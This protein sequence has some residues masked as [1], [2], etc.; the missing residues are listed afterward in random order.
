MQS[1]GR[2]L[3]GFLLTVVL[4]VCGTAVPHAE[5]NCQISES[6]ALRLPKATLFVGIVDAVSAATTAGA[7]VFV[8]VRV[9]EVFENRLGLTSAIRGHQISGILASGICAKNLRVGKQYLW[10]VTVR[11]VRNKLEMVLRTVG[12]KLPQTETYGRGNEIKGLD[13]VLAERAD[14]PCAGLHCHAGAVCEIWNDPS[15]ERVGVCTCMSIS[16]LEASGRCTRRLGRV[17]A[18]NGRLYDSQCHLLQA[19]CLQQTMV[20]IVSWTAVNEADCLQQATRNSKPGQPES[21]VSKMEEVTINKDKPA[22]SVNPYDQPQHDAAFMKEVLETPEAATCELSCNPDEIQ[23]VCGSDGRTYLN[24]CLLEHY[25]CL[26]FQR[27]GKHPVRVK[28]WGYCPAIELEGQ[29]ELCSFANVCLYG[30]RCTRKG[31]DDDADYVGKYRQAK[32]ICSC[33]HLSCE[34]T[35]NDK[36]V[37]G[38]D[39]ST[40]RSECF[41]RRAAC[42]SQSPKKV[43]FFEA[44]P[45]NPCL[46]QTCSW[47]GEQCRVD[48]RGGKQCVCRETCPRV[49]VP[50]CGSDG[51]TYDSVCVLERAACLQKKHV[52]VVHAGQCPQT[53]DECVRYGRPCKGYEVCI[54]RPVV[55][56]GLPSA[57]AMIMSRGSNQI[58]MTPQ[59]T[60]P[61]CPEDGLGNN[62]CGTDNRT[63]RSECHLRAAACRTK[64]LNLR[65]QSRGPC[66]A[67]KGIK[68]KF[69]SIC[70]TNKLGEPFCTCPTDCVYTGKWVCGSDGRAYENECFLRV[71]SCALQKEIYVLH[72]GKCEECSKNCP[73]GLMCLDG[74]CVCRETCPKS[75]LDQEVCGTDGRIYPSVCELRRQ[76]CLQKTTIK[77]D[78]S[79]VVCR[80]SPLMRNRTAEFQSDDAL[81]DRCH[82]NKIGSRDPYC[83]EDGTCRCHWGV[84][85]QKCDHCVEGYWGISNGKPCISCSCNRFGSQEI[86]S[87]DSHSGQCKCKEGITGQQCSI[88]PNGDPVTSKGCPGMDRVKIPSGRRQ[89]D[90]KEIGLFFGASTSALIPFED[91][92]EA[93]ISLH[94]NMTPLSANGEIYLLSFLPREGPGRRFLKLRLTDAHLELAYFTGPK[95]AKMN[96]LVTREKVALGEPMAVH[97]VLKADESLR[98]TTEEAG[99]REFGQDYLGKMISDNEYKQLL[100]SQYDG[101]V[102]GCPSTRSDQ[103]PSCGFSGCLTGIGAELTTPDGLERYVD[104]LSSGRGRHLRWIRAPEGA[105]LCETGVLRRTAWSDHYGVDRSPVEEQASLPEN[106]TSDVCGNENPCLHDGVCQSRA[107]VFVGCICPPGWQSKLCEKE[108]TIIP[109]FNGQ[110]YIR[111]DGPT[112]QQALKKR[113]MTLQ[114]IFTRSSNDGI[115]LAIPPSQPEAEFLS[116]RAEADDCVK[117]HLRVGR[118][119]RFYKLPIYPWLLTKFQPR[120]RIMVSKIC[121]VVHSRWHN[122]TIDKK[123]RQYTVYL[124]GKKMD[125]QTL[126]NEPIPREVRGLRKALTSFDLSHSPLYLGGIPQHETN[127]KVEESIVTN[128]FFVGAIQKVEINGAELVLAGPHPSNSATEHWEN[129]S[130]W[131]GPPCGEDFASCD[132]EPLR[133]ICRPHGEDYTCSCSTPLVHAVFVQRLTNSLAGVDLSIQEQK[134]I[135]TEAEELACA[136][137]M[138]QDTSRVIQGQIGEVQHDVP[139]DSIIRSFSQK[140]PPR[141]IENN[142]PAGQDLDA[143]KFRTTVNFNGSTILKYR[144][145][146]K[147]RK[148]NMLSNNLRLFIRTRSEN[149]LLLLIHNND[150]QSPHGQELLIL[151]VRNGQPEAYLSLHKKGSQYQTNGYQQ[152]TVQAETYVSDGMWHDIQVLRNKGR[153]TVI[154]DSY[155]ESGELPETDGVLHNDGYL[156]LGGFNAAVPS[157][158]SKYSNNFTGCVSAFFIDEQS[159][160]MLIDAE[161]IYGRVSPCQ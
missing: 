141:Q 48:T 106:P 88:C 46:G 122:L 127:L 81:I 95:F 108:V 26:S 63:Y 79:G 18:S 132:S 16:E 52:W 102:V 89:D 5:L 47:T 9:L 86:Q 36:P 90:G 96:Y 49:V 13:S 14:D 115:I 131:Q 8:D 111:L 142:S 117:I 136:E 83:D 33:E 45:E 41:L 4:V 37:C 126:P 159:V 17:C 104:L 116:I 128:N 107:G 22:R 146:L 134:R 148:I 105:T 58:L 3:T 35:W 138:G 87:C 30:G 92:V 38:D 110:A 158:P 56:S 150:R 84:E 21:Q 32:S 161:I 85:G 27:I 10:V 153:V 130:Q 137:R 53:I 67:C 103:H 113:R 20:N 40:Y 73:I 61:I 54:R 59:C 42:E 75:G 74:K 24:P 93:D 43:L 124:N 57:S 99:R 157:L 94:L 91:K 121:S 51:I 11:Q 44:C 135:S 69:F 68:C 109:E 98:I 123:T 152:V 7:T 112:G 25:S 39:G 66:D 118:L 50:V 120:E 76:A 55:K 154:V 140:G 28:S 1:A 70:Q 139:E 62:V 101:L 156:L 100:E 114:I 29:T 6:E 143:L 71:Q 2:I 15:R 119:S 97:C 34:Q 60:C 144:N 151:A 72:P 23:P 31:A 133:K 65:V 129:V 149:G 64:Q 77:I 82:C 19:T 147:T 12:K 80:K 78:G 125:Q 155:M 160:D 145:M